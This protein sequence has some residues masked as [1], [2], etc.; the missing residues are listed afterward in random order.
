MMLC[1]IVES[2]RAREREREG[3]TDG[4]TDRETDRDRSTFGCWVL[5]MS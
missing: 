1:F 5:H 3:R 2:E 4:R